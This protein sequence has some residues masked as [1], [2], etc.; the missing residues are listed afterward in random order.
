MQREL[1]FAAPCLFLAAVEVELDL[2]PNLAA[3]MRLIANDA[4]QRARVVPCSLYAS[5]E[6]RER[7]MGYAPDE[8][9]VSAQ[10]MLLRALYPNE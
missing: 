4:C 9:S 1:P 5:L 10:R 7:A 3:T 2:A 6:D 8:E